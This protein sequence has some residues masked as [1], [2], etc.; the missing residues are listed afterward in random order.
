MEKIKKNTYGKKIKQNAI[1]LG[2][3]Q[4][5]FDEIS[6]EEIADYN[7][8]PEQFYND[9]LDHLDHQKDGD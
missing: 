5:W 3:P 1:K 2:V 9:Y 7:W 8:T 6:N 4:W